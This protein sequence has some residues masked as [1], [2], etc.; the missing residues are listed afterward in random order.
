M[1]TID[2]SLKTR[3]AI[4]S[5]DLDFAF[6]I[7]GW[8]TIY[9]M[10]GDT[11]YSVPTTGDFSQFTAIQTGWMQP[12]SGSAAKM[13][14]RPEEGQST[15]GQMDVEII[16]ANVSGGRKLSDLLSRQAYLE[17]AS[18][19]AITTL[20]A[21]MTRAG[22]GT[23]TVASTAGFPAA[24]SVFFI[25]Q[26]CI[27]YDAMTGTTFNVPSGGRGYRLT[28]PNAH[29]ANVKV[30]GFFP[31]VYRQM[32][33]VYKGYKSVPLEKWARAYAG[34]ISGDSKAGA[35]VKF[36]I[37]SANWETY[38]DGKAR[39]F[40]P[41]VVLDTGKLVNLVLP[42]DFTGLSVDLGVLPASVFGNGHYVIRVDGSHWAI[43]SA[44]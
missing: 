1:Q 44:I 26:E 32:G 10:R 35:F 27:R 33:M 39:A 42:L 43:R 9:T 14:K 13:K 21:N 4:A 16:D 6:L 12:P 7:A 23:I 11:G 29:A 3:D 28:S 37:M 20:S 2:D 8:P 38:R 40:E 24:P 17:G 25:G 22:T 5:K 36:E 41:E 34:P 30:Y 18:A 15:I 19:G 31:S